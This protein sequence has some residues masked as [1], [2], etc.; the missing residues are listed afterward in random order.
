[1]KLITRTSLDL[2]DDYWGFGFDEDAGFYIENTPSR[3]MQYDNRFWTV[4]TF[5]V[6]LD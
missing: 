3:T 2:K 1:M 5:E 6:S 4:I